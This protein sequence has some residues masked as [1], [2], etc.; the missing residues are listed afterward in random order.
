M[1]NFV[2]V[3]SSIQFQYWGEEPTELILLKPGLARLD[4]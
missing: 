1:T 4:L 2:D 3:A